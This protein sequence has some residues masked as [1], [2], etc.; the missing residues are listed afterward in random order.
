[1]RGWRYHIIKLL[2]ICVDFWCFCN[3]QQYVTNAFNFPSTPPPPPSPLADLLA[4]GVS[5]T[6]KSRFAFRSAVFWV[7]CVCFMLPCVSPGD[8]RTEKW[9]MYQL[10]SSSVAS[11]LCTAVEEM[12]FLQMQFI[13]FMGGIRF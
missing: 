2:C 7:L 3:Y 13:F 1:M 11:E 6:L 12:Q 9:Q 10:S 5:D 8:D 4:V